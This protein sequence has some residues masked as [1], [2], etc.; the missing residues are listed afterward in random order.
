MQAP[1]EAT[2]AVRALAREDLAAVVEIDAAMQGRP[3][4]TYFERR[5]AA[6]V[7]EP[8]LHAQFGAADASGLA[9]Y[10]L[11]RV[12]EGEFG[13]DDT[14]LRLEVV[15][16]RRN[17]QGCGVG[18]ALFEALAGW[19]KRH[20][21]RDLRTLAAWNEHRMLRWLDAMRFTL[22][23]DHVLECAVGGGA[24]APVRDDAL[25]PEDAAPGEID[26]GANRGDRYER[27]ARDVVDVRAMADA[28]LDA[29]LRI[30]R[31][32][33]GRD[34]G[35]YIRAKHAEAMVDSAIRVSLTARLDGAIVGF[36]MASTDLGDFG[37]T[38]PVAILDTI[39]VDP[40]YA[41]HGVGH[42]LVSQLFSN[43]GALRIERVET[44]VAPRELALLGFLYE[45][46]FAPSQRMAFVRRIDT[47]R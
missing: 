24:Y 47:P 37:R 19:G 33:T 3:R 41:H 21:V 20:G 15:G 18:T 5:L 34:R 43:L 39:G 4:R 25:E 23:P 40:A 22:A 32:I 7:R 27:L 6:A 13:R 12:L 14:G 28:D 2:I 29:I 30:D 17:A 31:A 38:E 46:G 44:I 1:A 42:A 8:R 36:L 16:V 35:A 10:I 45:V 11:A 26:Y 9:G